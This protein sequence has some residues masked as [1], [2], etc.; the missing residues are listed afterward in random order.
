MPDYQSPN[1]GYE[2]GGYDQGKPVDTDS[3]PI[4][5]RDNRDE[6]SSKQ[7]IAGLFLLLLTVFVLSM[8]V[9]QMRDNLSISSSAKRSAATSKE[10]DASTCQGAECQAQYEASQR[11]KDTDRDGLSDYDELKVYGTSP[12]IED[13]DSDGLNDKTEIDRGSNPSCPEGRECVD[14]FVSGGAQSSSLNEGL[15]AMRSLPEPEELLNSAST[16]SGSATAKSINADEVPNADLQAVLSGQ[17]TAAQVR[18]AMLKSGANPD[19]LKDISDEQL[20]EV[21]K[22]ALEKGINK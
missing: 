8:W 3:P 20:M 2:A 5:Y 1:G 17:A 19:M 9:M 16:S 21:Y 14:S 4:Y 22:Q 15:E 13:S 10:G 18:E 6:F 11:Q 12:Y 7:K